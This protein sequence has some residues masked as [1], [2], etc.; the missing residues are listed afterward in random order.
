MQSNTML[1]AVVQTH[2]LGKRR[3]KVEMQECEPAIGNLYL[4]DWHAGNSSNR[5]LRVAEL[6]SSQGWSMEIDVLPKLFDAKVVKVT[7]SGMHLVGFEISSSVE[8][9][10]DYLQGWWAKPV[11]GSALEAD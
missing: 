1:F 8:V 7:S 3:T 5:N 11:A 10:A 2:V 6:K 9:T 4:F